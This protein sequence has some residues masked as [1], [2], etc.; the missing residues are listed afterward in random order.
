MADFFGLSGNESEQSNKQEAT[1]NNADVLDAKT[2]SQYRDNGSLQLHQEE[3]DISKNH[4]NI[5]EVVLSKEIVEE[6]KEI[7][8]P[9]THEE[10]IIERRPLNNQ[11]SNATLGSEE[12]IRI[13]VSEEHVE[14]NKHVVA[15]EEISAYKRAIEQTQHIEEILQ[16]EE[17]RINKSGDVN[18]ISEGENIT[19]TNTDEE[20]DDTMDTNSNDD[21]MN[22]PFAGLLNSGDTSLLN[23]AGVL[24]TLEMNEPVSN[25]DG[26]K[27]ANVNDESFADLVDNNYN[28]DIT[29][30]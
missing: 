8:I 1:Q 16:K 24:P 18:V 9:V 15:T 13:P 21:T 25:N 2:N 12:V 4:A 20:S 5:G 10:V 22:S 26:N 19:M 6:K 14:V 23:N 29:P 28:G 17:A 11:P 3:L 30:S 27:P 7:D